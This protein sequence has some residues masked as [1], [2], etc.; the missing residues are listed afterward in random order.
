MATWGAHIRIAENL[1]NLGFNL[2]EE[3][4]LVGNLAPDCN[5]ANED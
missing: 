4:F 5:Q 3:T 1:L 2:D